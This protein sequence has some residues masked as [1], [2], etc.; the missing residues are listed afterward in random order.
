MT[1][2]SSLS[3]PESQRKQPDGLH[4]NEPCPVCDGSALPFGSVDFNKTCLELSKGLFPFADSSIRYSQCS[5]CGHCFAPDIAKWSIAEFEDRIYNKDYVL[6]D[7]DYIEVRPR[8]NAKVLVRLFGDRGLSFKHL[9]YG[10]GQ[11]LLSQSLRE[12]GWQSSSYD[13]FVDRDTRIEQL[14]SF[15][16][17]TAYEVF[18]HVPNPKQLMADLCQLLSPNGLILFSTLV[19]D[20]YLLPDQRLSWWYASPR[21][22]HISLFSRRSLFTLAKGAGFNFGSLSEGFHCMLR[23]VP[24][25]AS[26]IITIHP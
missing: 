21:N 13:P 18:E 8:E 26:H 23:G 14:G 17:I 22:G 4:D 19:S 16:L 15:D 2:L 5:S 25:W 3:T 24:S 6:V 1:V 20:A 7:P 9:D 11:G 12:L 10:G